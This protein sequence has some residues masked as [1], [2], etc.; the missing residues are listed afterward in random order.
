MVEGDPAKM[1]ARGVPLG[2][3]MT[4]A[5]DAIDAVEISF[6]SGSA[7]GSLGFTCRARRSG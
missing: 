2:Q 7:V 1:K 6:T 5:A 3:L 4:T